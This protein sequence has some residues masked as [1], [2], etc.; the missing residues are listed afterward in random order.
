MS[1]GIRDALTRMRVVVIEQIEAFD[2]RLIGRLEPGELACRSNPGHRRQR[3]DATAEAAAMNRIINP[4]RPYR[5]GHG[6]LVH[7]ATPSRK[8]SCVVL[9]CSGRTVSDCYLEA[10]PVTPDELCARCA[11]KWPDEVRVRAV[12]HA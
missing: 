8:P 10:L 11:S 6:G 2:V 7:L 9:A 5:H 3:K 12:Y 4:R 1:R